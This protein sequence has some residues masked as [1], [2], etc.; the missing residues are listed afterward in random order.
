MKI[1][2]LNGKLIFQIGEN[3][4]ASS[5]SFSQTIRA[6]QT[7]FRIISEGKNLFDYEAEFSTITNDNGDVYA[8][9]E[10]LRNLL[11]SHFGI[12]SVETMSEITVYQTSTN[13]MFPANVF[14]AISVVFRGEGGTLKGIPV[15]DGYTASFSKDNGGKLGQ[16]SFTAPTTGEARVIYTTLG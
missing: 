4:Y 13:E 15:P 7:F 11:L 8:D 14:S 5:F 3:F 10:T 2:T 1:Y 6:G 9:V 12:D 16:I